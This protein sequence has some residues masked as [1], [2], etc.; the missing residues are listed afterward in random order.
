MQR[1]LAVGPSSREV[2][3][4]IQQQCHNFSVAGLG[5]SVQWLIR[6]AARL[7]PGSP[8]KEQTGDSSVAAFSAM[9]QRCL[10]RCILEMNVRPTIKK[11]CDGLLVSS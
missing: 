11:R 7:M 8:V 5:S 2:G 4:S 9:V 10:A 3:T 1:H 6:R